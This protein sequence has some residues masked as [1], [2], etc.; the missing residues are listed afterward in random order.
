MKKL[1][2]HLF[3]ALM[4]L[5]LTVL[6]P[7]C[8]S[9]E[10]LYNK[11]KYDEAVTTFVKKLQRKPQDANANRLLPDAYK[12]AQ[13]EREDKVNEYLRSNN[14]L[15]W[16]YVRNEY[17][18][19]QN[20]YTSIHN[21]PAALQLVQPKDYRN[22]ITGA[23]ENAAEVR[24]D[25]GIAL[26]DKGD[27]AS[28]RAAYDEFGTALKLIPDYRDA[29]QLRDQAFQMAVIRVIVSDIEVRSPYYQFSA[30]Q[31]R[32]YLVRGLQQRNINP[33]VQF[34]DERVASTENIHPDEYIALRFFDFV[35]GQTYENRTQRDVSKDIVAG[36]TKDSTGKETNTYKTVKATLYITQKTVVSK[37]LLDY[38]I[39]DTNNGQLLRSDRIPGS[40]TWQNQYG[41]FKGD[42]RALSDEDK[43]LMGG[44]DVAPPPP[45]DLFM[46][47]TRP[48]YDVLT[49]DLQNLYNS[50]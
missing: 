18:A 5:F 45:T 31:F 1:A 47:F 26:L 28:A 39:T 3:I 14:P 13:R 29:Q 10:K 24:Y 37:G 32:D 19:L 20:L 6:L 48:I 33:F 41:T 8:K 9:G 11:G 2:S 17:K 12:L 36:T 25:R 4:A 15:K 42:E 46:E 35:V 50:L 44:R 22:A 23:Q 34:Y 7:G 30:D 21:S 38:Q 43:R 27:K 40:Y 16:E 49:R